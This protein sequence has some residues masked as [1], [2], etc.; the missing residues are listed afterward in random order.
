M[1]DR[2]PE[3]SNMT[4]QDRRTASTVCGW[5]LKLVRT[6]RRSLAISAAGNPS[7]N[8]DSRHQRQKATPAIAHDATQNLKCSVCQV[9][10]VKSL[11]NFFLGESIARPQNLE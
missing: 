8:R 2:G 11:G 10:H 6:A 1:A 3:M 5:F 7:R 4:D 9:P